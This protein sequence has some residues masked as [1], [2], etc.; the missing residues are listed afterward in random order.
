MNKFK[1]LVDISRHL[2]IL[3]TVF[4]LVNWITFFN[5]IFVMLQYEIDDSF[6][7]IGILG[8]WLFISI[9]YGACILVLGYLMI[10]VIGIIEKYANVEVDE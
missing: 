8:G 3:A 2:W 10:K 5:D 6:I 4:M 7:Y 1:V 9:F